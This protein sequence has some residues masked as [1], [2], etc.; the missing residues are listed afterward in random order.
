MLAGVIAAPSDYSPFVNLALAR[1]RQHHVLD[2][3]VESGYITQDASREAAD[4]PLGPHQANARRDCKAISI[5]TSRR[6]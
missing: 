2:R 1:D 3:M 4:A 6:T 5:R